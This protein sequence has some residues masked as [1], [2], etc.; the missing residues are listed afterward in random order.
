MC[1]CHSKVLQRGF[2]VLS[3]LSKYMHLYVRGNAGVPYFPNYKSTKLTIRLFCVHLQKFRAQES[4][5][6]EDGMS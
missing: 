6:Q 5:E 2:G 1:F 3:L 4:L